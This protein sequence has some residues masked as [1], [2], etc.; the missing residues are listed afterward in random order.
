[1]K[2]T[3][4]PKNANVGLSKS[5]SVKVIKTCR[6]A[7]KLN[8]TVRLFQTPIVFQK[9]DPVRVHSS[10][11]SETV[12]KASGSPRRVFFLVPEMK[13]NQN[14][15]DF[16]EPVQNLAIPTT[17]EYMKHAHDFKTNEAEAGFGNHVVKQSP[18]KITIREKNKQVK[19][20]LGLRRRS[21]ARFKG[22]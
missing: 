16:I 9:A 8:V 12:R 6:L 20:N 13:Y 5:S 1:M 10:H 19:V 21:E 2:S 22:N 17:E 15:S 11:S 18:P 4:S 3:H 7:G 14:P